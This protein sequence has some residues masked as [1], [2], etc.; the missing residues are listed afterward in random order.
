VWAIIIEG[1]W[2]GARKQWGMLWGCQAGQLWKG[3]CGRAVGLP[4]RRVRKLPGRLGSKARAVIRL[5]GAELGEGYKEGQLQLWAT[6]HNQRE[7]NRGGLCWGK[8][9]PHH[10]AGSR[11]NDHIRPPLNGIHPLQ[12]GK[13]AG[14][15]AAG[16]SRHPPWGRRAAGSTF[17]QNQLA[18]GNQ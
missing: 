18:R 10:H 13:G 4:G 1:V 8:G 7:P 16:S 14:G 6:R 2:E 5:H 3:M 12:A 11:F 15:R 9:Q 17:I